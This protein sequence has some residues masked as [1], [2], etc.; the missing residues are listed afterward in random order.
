MVRDKKVKYTC[1]F[2]RGT[3]SMLIPDPLKQEEAYKVFM[4]KCPFCTNFISKEKYKGVKKN[5]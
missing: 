1:N 2:C 4:I 5:D 3:F